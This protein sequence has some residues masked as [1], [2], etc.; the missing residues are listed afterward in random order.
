MKNSLYIDQT[1]K[2]IKL[3]KYEQGVGCV[4]IVYKYACLLSQCTQ[5]TS[6]MC[7]SKNFNCSI[8]TIWN[9]PLPYI[10]QYSRPDGQN[11][12]NSIKSIFTH[13]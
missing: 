12:Y 13:P 6:L 5:I 1:L 2:P 8:F 7:L 4:K 9:K 10:S 3:E 11:I